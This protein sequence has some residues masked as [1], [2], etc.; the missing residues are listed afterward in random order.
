MSSESD[1]SNVDR[2]EV[3]DDT[4]RAYVKGSMY[5]TPVTVDLSIQ[6]DGKT[7]KVF[8]KNRGATQKEKE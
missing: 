6:D 7:L 1:F 4:G 3:I 5:G 8:V 2:I